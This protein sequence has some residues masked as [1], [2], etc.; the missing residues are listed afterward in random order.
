M[1]KKNDHVNSST[2]Y[3]IIEGFN[4]IWKMKLPP[5][6][7]PGPYSITVKSSE[8]EVTINDVMFGD[9]WLCSGQSNMQFTMREVNSTL[10]L[11]EDQELLQENRVPAL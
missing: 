2:L 8:G 1:R 5:E 7:H 6:G 9:V 4:G 3:P 11:S 10:T